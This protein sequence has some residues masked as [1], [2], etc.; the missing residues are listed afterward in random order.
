MGSFSFSSSSSSEGLNSVA[1][2]R[3]RTLFSFCPDCVL[4]RVYG[5][6][7]R[8]ARSGPPNPTRGIRGISG[9]LPRSCHFRRLPLPRCPAARG[10][11]PGGSGRP[12]SCLETLSIRLRRS[13]VGR[14]VRSVLPPPSPDP[15]N[16]R[17]HSSPAVC[18]AACCK[19]NRAALWRSN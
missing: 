3:G 19:T 17:S 14:E 10:G 16:Q 7:D 4:T 15:G 9:S 12:A 18:H 1:V 5:S 6:M 11:L 13:L 8:S 2:S